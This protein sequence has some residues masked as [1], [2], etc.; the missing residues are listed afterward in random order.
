MDIRQGDPSQRMDLY[1]P[2]PP[3]AEGVGGQ[4]AFVSGSESLR[5]EGK[6]WPERRSSQII[7]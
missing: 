2:A 4:G 1:P 5:L 7:W 3:E 6:K